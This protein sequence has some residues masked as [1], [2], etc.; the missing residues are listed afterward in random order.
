MRVFIEELDMIRKCLFD[1]VT[2]CES[3][4]SEFFVMNSHFVCLTC[5]KYIKRGKL[6]PMSNQNKLSVFDEHHPKYMKKYDI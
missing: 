3:L 1:D 2:G 4:R 5:D 6:P